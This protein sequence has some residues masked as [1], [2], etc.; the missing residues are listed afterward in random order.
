MRPLAAAS[1][2]ITDNR[3]AVAL[4]LLGAELATSS[5]SLLWLSA[6]APLCMGFSTSSD[7]EEDENGCEPL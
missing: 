3:G 1:L 6:V 2:L 5:A 4:D 7:T